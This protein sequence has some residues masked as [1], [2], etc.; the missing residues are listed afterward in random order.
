MKLYVTEA[1]REFDTF[2]EAREHA[3]TLP[4]GLH[5]LS[6]SKL[7]RKAIAGLRDYQA[8]KLEEQNA[9]AWLEAHNAIL[10]A[11]RLP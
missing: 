11:K 5:K 7:H 6:L 4:K 9:N 8:K 1:G 10:K 3:K 2:K